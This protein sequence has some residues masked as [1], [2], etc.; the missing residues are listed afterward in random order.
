MVK[1]KAVLTL[2]LVGSLSLYGAAQILPVSQ[3]Q[4]P[5]CQRMQR[6]YSSLLQQIA[7]AGMNTHFPYHFYFNHVLDVDESRQKQ[8]PQGSVHFDRFDDEIVLEITGNYYASYSAAAMNA[9]QRARQTFQDVVL[10]LLKVAVA[11]VDRTIPFGA[12]A[13]EISHHVRTRTAGID[14]ENPENLTLLLP[15]SGA[16]RL[17]QARDVESQQAVILESEVYLNG[18]PL[19]LWLV[20]DDAPSDVR[21]HYVEQYK[22]D[23]DSNSVPSQRPGPPQSRHAGGT[24]PDPLVEEGDLVNP[25]LLGRPR[26]QSAPQRFG[27]DSI[28]DTSPGRMV[29]LQTTYESTLDQLVHDLNEQAKFVAYAPP[30]FV[31]FHEAAYLQLSMT[32]DLAQ[33]G[34][35]SQYRIAAL[36]FDQHISHLLRPVFKYFRDSPQFEG[37]DFSTTVHEEGQPATESVEFVIPFSALRCYEKYDCSGQQL[38]NH[39]IVLINGERVSLDLERAESDYGARLP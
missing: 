28:E 31:P 38:I 29:K 32:T 11:H 33:P 7:A 18:K 10:P 2:L 20:G 1:N 24:D 12:Y 27:H 9:N 21:D 39:S 26:F 13:F 16:E 19:A 4:D 6:K 23:A 15:R 3:I 8:L 14:S 30:N 34:G 37:I 22:R 35:T 25:K 5:A 17:V 36:A